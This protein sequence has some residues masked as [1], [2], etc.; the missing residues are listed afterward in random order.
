H[1]HDQVPAD[2]DVHVVMDNY[3][4]HKTPA[5]R[6]WFARHPHFKP[7]FTPTSASWINQVER[8]FADLTQKQIRRGTHR[9][10][11]AL[12]AAIRDYLN[13]YN[14]NPRPFAWTKSADDILASIKRFC[15]RTSNSGH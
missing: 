11:V 2:L 3:G 6:S 15:Q 7:H 4:T 1:L 10:T 13:T 8:W 14:K 12:E 5:V 9:S